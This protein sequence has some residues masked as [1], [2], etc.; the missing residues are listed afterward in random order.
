MA[1][2]L[3][4][5][6]RRMASRPDGPVSDPEEGCGCFGECESLRRR[7]G[8]V[9]E[10]VMQTFKCLI[11]TIVPKANFFISITGQGRH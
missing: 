9:K 8:E 2:S 7:S 10:L 6:I 3:S 5:L 11:L 4:G 1:I